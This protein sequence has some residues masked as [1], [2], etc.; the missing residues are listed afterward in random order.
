MHDC[1]QFTAARAHGWRRRGFTLIELLVVIAIT[2]ILAA[3]LFPVYGAARRKAS[4]TACLSN[5]KQLSTALRMYV[6]DAGGRYP[7]NAGPRF[8]PSQVADIG[9]PRDDPS[10]KSNRL[11]GAPVRRLLHPYVRSGAVWYCPALPLRSARTMESGSLLPGEED[12]KGEGVAT[13]YQVNPYVFVNSIP[14]A[15]LSGV[16]SERPHAGPVLESDVILPEK[17]RIFQDFWNQT[18]GVHSGGVNTARAD[19]SAAWQK[20]QI[21]I[22]NIVWWAQQ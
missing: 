12:P 20:A 11:D 4:V 10:D 16:Q 22:T 14:Y 19:G 8:S 5:L 17:L 9:L 6:D 3:I 2:A 21:G 1:G 18:G 7:W 13:D 15:R